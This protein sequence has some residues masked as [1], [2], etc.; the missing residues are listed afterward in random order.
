M[1]TIRVG[2]V[3]S[4]FVSTIHLEALRS[5]PATEVVAVTSATEAHAR[6]FAERHGIPRWFTD[7]R[8]MYELPDLD[9]VVLGLPNDLHCDATV[10]AAAAGKHILCEKPLCLNLAEADRMIDACRAAGVKLMY[11]EELCFTPKYVRLKHL[12]D[13]GALGRIH[14][15]KQAEKHDGPHAAWFWD[16]QRSGGGVTMDMGCHAIEFF[17]WLLGGRD[18]GKARV[19]SVYADMGTHVHGGRT[20]G[21]DSSTLILKLDGD[22]TATAEESWAK[23]GGMDDRAEVYG[24]E[25][26]AYADLLRGNAIHTYSKRGYGYAVEKAGATQGWSFTI[27]EE[28][29][30]YGFHQEMAHFV[31][32]VRDD[33]PPL[34]TGE[35]GRVVLEVVF[36][37]Y[38]SA[39]EGR[40]IDLPFRTDAQRPIDLWRKA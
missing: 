12:V 35:D 40:R 3:G 21:D 28:A 37:A 8:K 31:G 26:V 24:S 14:L 25:G 39:A 38:A 17:R 15:V 10:S 5:V 23:P 33:R 29:W 1:K 32:C 2:L 4:Q 34:C 18:G 22:V 9:L 6:A 11:A 27:Y 13:E 30:N 36:A 19:R 7:Y 20:R 16:V